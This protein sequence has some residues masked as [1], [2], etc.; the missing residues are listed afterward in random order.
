MK[1]TGG[2]YCKQIRY[3]FEGDVM[4]SLHREGEVVSTSHEDA[5]IRVRARL[6]DAA[7]GRLTEFVVQ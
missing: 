7:R 2:C 3:S 5:G 4:A 6:A 1:L